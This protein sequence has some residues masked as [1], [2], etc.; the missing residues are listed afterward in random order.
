[1]KKSVIAALV[2]ASATSSSM[3]AVIT[4]IANFTGTTGIAITDMA[5]VVTPS[6]SVAVGT[7][8]STAF[9]D[10][11][12]VR[13]MFVQN[14]SAVNSALPFAGFF[15]TQISD[16][17]TSTDGSDSFVGNPIYIV[18]GNNTSFAASTDFIVYQTGVNW[19]QE[20]PAV[21]ATAL[22]K[23]DSASST[24]LYGTETVTSGATG[25]FAA[26][27][28]TPGVTFGVVPEPSVAL[29]GMLGALGLIR[30]RR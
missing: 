21:G 6:Y 22:A 16:A 4:T 18:V 5:G 27:N 26:N 3:G 30:R 25:A 29:L 14:G 28:G 10:A 15:N 9:S 2:L 13:T 20:A 19:P 7:F 11:D 8:T 1:M 12:S 17:A 24:L 23:T